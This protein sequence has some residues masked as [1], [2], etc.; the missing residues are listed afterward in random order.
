MKLSQLAADALG[1]SLELT[2]DCEIHSLSAD[3]RE[4]TDQ[5]LF[6]CIRGAHY[7]S[8]HFAAQAVS[9]GAAALVVTELQPQIPVPQLKVSNDRAAMA[10]IARA[11]FGFADQRMKLIG[12][13]GTKGKTTT[14]YLVK[15]ILE[16]SGYICGLIGT[17]GNMIASH[18]I[19][20][21]LTTPD[22][23]ELHRTLR[24]M[25]QAG[26]EYVIMEVSAH[27][28]WMRRLEGLV[29]E[30]G[31]FTNLSQDHLDF[32]GTME[33]YFMAKRSFFMNSSIKNAVISLD[34]PW[35]FRLSQELTMPKISYAICTNA[36]L[37]A[38]DIQIEESG[39]SFMLSLW[40]DKYY[41]VRLKLMGMFNIYN[42]I[43]AAGIGL[44]VGADP[45]AICKA[46]ES[47]TSVPGRAEILD[48]NTDYMVVLDYS[49]SPDALENILGAIREFIKGRLIVVFGCGGDRDQGKRPIMGAIAGKMADFSILTSDNPRAED[50]LDILNAIEEG[51]KPTGARY[52]VIENRREAIKRALKTAQAGDVVLL[53]GKGHETYQEIAGIKRPFNEKIIVSELLA[54]MKTEGTTDA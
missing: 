20:S 25:A 39:V 18:W 3:S 8:H 54:E 45:D 29:F 37:F 41:P 36:D 23:I 49:H 9:N 28:V 4:R 7:D 31:C 10:L 38:R 16:A 32:F 1:Y 33:D 52:E 2:G 46:L 14:S 17:T 13:T 51:I 26:C 21:S 35:A 43:A 22:P 42:A 53:A 34:D 48:T 30:A 11:F 19:N 6:F 44:V 47:V 50:P 15:A 5:A 12:I 27:A 40:N 24:N